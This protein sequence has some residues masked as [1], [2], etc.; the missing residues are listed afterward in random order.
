VR[1]QYQRDAR[2]RRKQAER[3]L[4]LARCPVVELRTDRSYVP[5][6]IRYFST[7]RARRARR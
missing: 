2:D 5:T 4:A 1:D 3:S 6:L 7:R